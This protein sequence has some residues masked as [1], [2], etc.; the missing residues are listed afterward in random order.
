MNSALTLLVLANAAISI[1]LLLLWL[2]SRKQTQTLLLEASA[3][4]TASEVIPANLNKLVLDHK[5]R[6][7]TVEI[8]NPIELAVSKTVFA[9]PLV[10][11]SPEA[12]NKIVYRQARDIVAQ[13]LP[14]F[15]VT[16][17][18]KIHVAS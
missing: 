7:I 6:V 11:M 14:G 15:G 4:A 8:L 3:L 9:R 12:I 13:Q 5:K 10:G 17:E 1:V 16:A 18:V 2:R